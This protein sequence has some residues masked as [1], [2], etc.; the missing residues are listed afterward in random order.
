MSRYAVTP[1][2]ASAALPV[3]KPSQSRAARLVEVH[4]RV[5]AAGE[6]VQPAA[7][8]LEP[9]PALELPPHRGDHAPSTTPDARRSTTPAPSTMLPPRT[10]TS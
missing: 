7:F 4:V 1:P 6:H 5:E 10:I 8:D 2:A 9:R 3:A